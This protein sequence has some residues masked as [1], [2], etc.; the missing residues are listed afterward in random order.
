MR[1]GI[2][3]AAAR[4]HVIGDQGGLPWHLPDDL[5]RFR[6]ITYGHPIIMGRR[7]HESIGR[8]L[9]G[10]LNIVLTSAPERVA[11]GCVAVSTLESAL[12]VARAADT[13]EVFVVGGVSLYR[14][15]YDLAE[16]VYLTRIEAEVE[17]DTR[18]T[19][20]DAVDEPAWEL[21]SRELHSA[22]ARHSFA[23]TYLVFE[24]THR[25]RCDTVPRAGS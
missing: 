24:R 7:T 11:N 5:K 20:L 22:D 12:E 4:N 6:S 15:T 14:S 16:R 13:A 10:R 2:V 23:F 9:S 18:W 19:G 8:V 17:G 21:V 3:V 25:A 1:L